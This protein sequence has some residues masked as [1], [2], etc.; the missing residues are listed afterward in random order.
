M[1]L[2]E[3]LETKFVLQPTQLYGSEETKILFAMQLEQTPVYLVQ[4]AQLTPHE[5]QVLMVL[6]KYFPAGQTF[7]AVHVFF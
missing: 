6:F 7:S 1:Q 4:L 5:R 3:L 2:F